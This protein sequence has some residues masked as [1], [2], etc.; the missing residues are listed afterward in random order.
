MI[1]CLLETAISRESMLDSL[2]LDGCGISSPLTSDFLDSVSEKLSSGAAL[3]YLSFTCHG[4]DK[5]DVDSMRQVWMDH[6]THLG[7]ADIRGETVRLS[8]QENM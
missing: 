2:L 8:V 1:Q 6:W 7:C 3:R 5:V 4:L